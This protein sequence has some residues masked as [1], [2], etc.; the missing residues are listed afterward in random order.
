MN[1]N[2]IAVFICTCNN[3]IGTNIDLDE[4]ESKLNSSS[5]NITVKRHDSLCKQEGQKF[6][7]DTVKDSEIDRVVIAACTPRTYEELIR[8][9]VIESGIGSNLYEQIGIREQCEWVHTDK[10]K[11]TSKAV[12]LVNCGIAKVAIAEKLEDEELPIKC[13]DV[14]IIGGGIAG[15]RA[16]L[17]LATRG[18][19]CFIVERA[20]ELGGMANK[21]SSN[22]L[23]EVK[24]EIPVIEDV[25]NNDNIEVI[26]GSEINDI[27]GGLGNYSVSLKPQEGKNDERQFEVG[28]IIIATGTKLFE[29][30]RI[31][32]FGYHNSDVITSL[33]LEEMLKIQS[34]TSPS[35][36]TVP[37]RIN[38]IQCVGSRDDTK[39]NSYCSLVCCT[40]SLRQALE[41]KALNPNIQIY[42]HYMDLRGPYS[43][44]EELYRD[45]QDK[46]VQLI[47]GRVAE[48]QQV[49]GKMMLRAENID[50]EELL[51]WYTD[52]VVLA[53][54]QEPSEGNDK[55]SELLYIPLDIDGFLGEYNYRWDIVDRRGI[56]IIGSAQGPRDLRHTLKDATRAATEL[57]ELFVKGSVTIDGYSHIDPNRCMG[58]GICVALCPYNAITL[59]NLEDFETEEVRQVSEVDI[60]VCQSCGACAMSCPSNVPV[61]TKNTADQIFTEIE[62]LI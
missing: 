1:E 27:K 21:L 61:L 46:G 33:E 9:G 45:A 40:Y 16:A 26:V 17:D 13:K 44:F 36:G 39:G 58:C 35:N 2:K 41:I 54:G 12:D 29:P 32:E 30:A 23:A 25:M 56:S 60:T 14:L 10:S 57:A 37:K 53:V 38:F 50:L 49:D 47:R 11:A 4:L 24:S 62:A 34:I 52:L 5:N 3:Q 51:E 31:P 6:L 19:H 18:L 59:K 7:M 48:V 28:G 43:G 8:K 55:L 15:M 42:I 20:S 22:T